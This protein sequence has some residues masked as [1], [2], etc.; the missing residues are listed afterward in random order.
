MGLEYDDWQARVAARLDLT[1]M[2]THLT[3]PASN[4]SG[5]DI[6]EIHEAATINLI[7]ILK[8][9]VLHGSTTGTGFIV[10]GTPAVCFQNVPFYGLI[11]NVKHE[12]E[13]RE[14]NSGERLRYC[15]VGLA[16][17]KWHVF[18]EGGRPVMY[19]KTSDAKL[20]LEPKEHWRIVNLNWDQVTDTYVDWTH[21]REWR[22]PHSYKF[23]LLDCH[24]VL[25]DSRCWKYFL[26]K[27]PPN[28]L[29]EVRG[30][31]VLKSIM[32]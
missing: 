14:K 1:G 9:Q 5:M 30:I 24:V 2:L 8:E 16:F 11:Q 21:E 29:Q 26:R 20:L 12:Q 17:L 13:R 3:K 28:I 18:R 25:Y 23:E 10:G 31:S 4:T 32:L 6:N 27:C 15:G 7:Q 22:I 19:E